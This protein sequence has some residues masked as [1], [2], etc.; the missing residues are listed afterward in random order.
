[1]GN[2]S[3]ILI[4]RHA[5]KPKDS[6]NENLSTKGYERAAALVY[7]FL[8]NF[9][10]TDHIF[11]AG[12]GKHSP[13]NRPIETITPTAHR[14][15]LIIHEEF[16]KDQFR[17]MVKHILAND[18]YINKQIIICWE[19]TDI[20]AIATAFGALH[21]PKAAP[22]PENRFDLVWQ[23]SSNLENGYN[24]VQHPQKLMYGDLD[25]IIPRI[26]QS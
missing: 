17:A 5:E 25:S 23:L 19:H 1:M 4:L 18:K 2:P 20:E 21:V 14:L 7:Y 9:P 24:L 12:I 3:T 22:W 16:L 11:A 15:Y 6:S 26:E 13:S 8:H 10:G